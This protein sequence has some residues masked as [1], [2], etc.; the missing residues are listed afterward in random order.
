MAWPLLRSAG[1]AAAVEGLNSAAHVA[2][3]VS[4]GED[5]RVAARKRALQGSNNLLGK[6][7]ENLRKQQGKGVG[8]RGKKV[9]KTIKRTRKVK[10]D[11][12]PM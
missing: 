9:T 3:D 5:W 8:K 2:K 11:I 4:Q 7:A 12:F 1:T 10:K 6:A